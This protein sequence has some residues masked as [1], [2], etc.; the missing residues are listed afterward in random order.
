[1]KEIRIKVAPNTKKEG[2]E[3][4]KDGRLKVSVKADRRGGQANIRA[5]EILAGFLKVPAEDISIISGHTSPTK[6]LRIK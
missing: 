4:L 2:V 6:T 3:E 1:M 5:I